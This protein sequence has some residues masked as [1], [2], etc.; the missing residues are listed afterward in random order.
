ME[1]TIYRSFYYYFYKGKNLDISV[2]LTPFNP[3][4]IIKR[5]FIMNIIIVVFIE[6]RAIG[7][8]KYYI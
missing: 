8:F 3:I 6:V 4:I 1:I 2:N 7:K 5:G